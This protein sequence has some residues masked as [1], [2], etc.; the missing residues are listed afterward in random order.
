MELLD[1]LLTVKETAKHLQLN[2]LTVYEYIKTGK[3]NAVKFGR[4]YRIVYRDLQAFINAH[5]TNL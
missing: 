4:Y 5:K 3:L 1:T 2:T